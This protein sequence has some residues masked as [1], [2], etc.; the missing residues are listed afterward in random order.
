[1]PQK[2]FVGGRDKRGRPMVVVWEGRRASPLSQWDEL[3]ALSPAYD[4][5]RDNLGAKQ[6]A[7]DLIGCALGEEQ[8][9]E[10]LAQTFADEVVFN[11]PREWSLTSDEI[12]RWVGDLVVGCLNL[13]KTQREDY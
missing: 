12:V 7:H 13:A 9:A 2:V 11:L 10:V 5:G 3:N 6:L 8:V 4:W 1:M